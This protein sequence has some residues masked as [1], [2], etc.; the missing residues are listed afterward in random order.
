MNPKTFRVF[1]IVL[2]VLL[3]VVFFLGM[4]VFTM[5]S[6]SFVDYLVFFVQ[7][8]VA[9]FGVYYLLAG[10]K[11]GEGSRFFKSFMMTFAILIFI[12]MPQAK[13]MSVAGVMLLMLQFGALCILCFGKDLGKA[14]SFALAWI[15]TVCSVLRIPVVIWLET[16]DQASILKVGTLLVLSCVTLLM[17]SAK[18]ADKAARGRK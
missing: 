13:D 6:L 4:M 8:A 9:I 1:S 2:S 5:E 3:G 10:C 17:V 15:V 12:S 7:D 16:P 14:F 11:K 18:Y